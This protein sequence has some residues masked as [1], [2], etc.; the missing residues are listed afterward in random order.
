MINNAIASYD[1][2]GI[3]HGIASYLGTVSEHCSEFLQARLIYGFTLYNDILFIG[4]DI[5]CDRTR[6]HMGLVS[7]NAVTHI[8][9]MRNLYGV[10]KNDILKFG[11]ITDNAVLSNNN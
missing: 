9:V 10:E 2:S 1:R 6:T 5:R 4:F 7:E 11:G 8:I 3:E